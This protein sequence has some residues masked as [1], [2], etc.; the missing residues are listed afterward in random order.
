M[1]AREEKSERV[2]AVKS[3][4]ICFWSPRQPVI[5]VYVV[6]SAVLLWYD[7]KLGDSGTSAIVKSIFCKDVQVWGC[8]LEAVSFCSSCLMLGCNRWSGEFANDKSSLSD[9]VNYYPC[10]KV[11][12]LF[13]IS[14]R[15]LMSQM[16]KVSVKST[17]WWFL[18]FS[19]I[20]HFL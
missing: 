16:W 19:L 3:R 17:V 2:R 4:T 14:V 12:L 20:S 11:K 18:M 15:N 13:Q 6:N 10:Q 1:F 5:V 7:Q 9:L 8:D